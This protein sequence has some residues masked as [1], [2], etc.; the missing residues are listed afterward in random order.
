MVQS[1]TD[2]AAPITTND[3]TRTSEKTNT[4]NIPSQF[5]P[6]DASTQRFR[7]M[8]QARSN[9]NTGLPDVAIDGPAPDKYYD[10]N[11]QDVIPKLPKEHQEWAKNALAHMP[12]G[13]IME[14]LH[15]GEIAV[16]NFHPT[17][18][19]KKELTAITDDMAKKGETS[20][21]VTLSDGTRVQIQIGTP[22][23]NPSESQNNLNVPARKPVTD[24][25]TQN[26]DK[27]KQNPQ[28]AAAGSSPDA[29][30]PTADATTPTDSRQ[31]TT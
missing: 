11:P 26:K 12:N 5:T 20:R 16:S 27:K 2:T 31:A 17:Q 4:P 21:L 24:T 3:N 28:Y 14:G 29:S 1:V 19:E 22:A 7:A 18:Q 6:G 25:E 15:P 9:G 10:Q 8:E 30:D 13:H 23:S